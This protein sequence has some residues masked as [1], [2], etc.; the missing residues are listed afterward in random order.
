ML[1][2]VN[3]LREVINQRDC[4]LKVHFFSVFKKGLEELPQLERE[5]RW[6]GI[7]LTREASPFLCGS[8]LREGDSEQS[9][10]SLAFYFER[11]SNSQKSY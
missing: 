5:I 4:R 11:V 1:S 7:T 2:V 3:K 8:T 9:A 10:R 6:S